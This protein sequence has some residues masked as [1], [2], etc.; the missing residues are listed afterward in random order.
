MLFAK[1]NNK[2]ALIKKRVVTTW[3]LQVKLNRHA[4]SRCLQTRQQTGSCVSDLLVTTE[5]EIDELVWKDEAWA[6][7]VKEKR[8]G[9][10]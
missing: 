9:Q 1:E 10:S 5:V 3:C 8:K 2:Q 6:S 4:I 7:E